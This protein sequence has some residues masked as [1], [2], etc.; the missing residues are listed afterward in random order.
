MIVLN[1]GRGARA[2]IVRYAV[3]LSVLTRGRGNQV[4]DHIRDLIGFSAVS[5]QS[6]LQVGRPGC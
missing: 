1:G 5:M 3:S 2:M 4:I 6:I